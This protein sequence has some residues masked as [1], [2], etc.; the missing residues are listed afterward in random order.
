MQSLNSMCKEHP[1]FYFSLKSHNMK[2]DK[3]LKLASLR[4]EEKRGIRA[5]SGTK[6]EELER[7]EHFKHSSPAGTKR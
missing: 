7:S 2:A 5:R 3:L 4:E 1:V 6:P